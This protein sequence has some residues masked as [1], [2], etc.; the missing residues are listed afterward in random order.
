MTARARGAAALACV[1]LGACCAGERLLSERISTL[2][3]VNG[4]RLRRYA[5]ADP[6][7]KADPAAKA[8]LAGKIGEMDGAAK[9]G[10]AL[11]AAAL[12]AGLGP[13]LRAY[14]AAD[15]AL[16][17]DSRRIRLESVDRM[18]EAAREAKGGGP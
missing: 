7:L 14:L 13:R 10:P 17:P 16:D 9:G 11:A 4:P 5:D 12:W 15:A 2:W 1:L 8:E 3:G 18:D 6:A